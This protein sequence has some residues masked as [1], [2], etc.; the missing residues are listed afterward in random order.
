MIDIVGE[1]EHPALLLLGRRKC[2]RFPE[3]FIG[4]IVVGAGCS[5]NKNGPGA[6]L[7]R[8]DDIESTVAVEITENSILGMGRSPG[9]NGG[10]DLSG[11]FGAW[12]QT[13]TNSVSFLPTGHDIW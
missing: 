13:D 12:I 10:P 6:S 7:R 1:A 2:R 4:E 8:T 5:V 11:G 9:G 3:R